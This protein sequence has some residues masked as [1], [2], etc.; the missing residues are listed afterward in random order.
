ML[1]E[2]RLLPEF[3]PEMVQLQVGTGGGF[4]CT[5]CA[6]D[7]RC[8]SCC[9]REAV[10]TACALNL[11]GSRHKAHARLGARVCVRSWTLQR[12]CA[13]RTCSS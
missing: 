8:S 4:A 11:N 7:S 12:W 6:T 5:K 1:K 2:P 10:C 3:V 13:R 9:K